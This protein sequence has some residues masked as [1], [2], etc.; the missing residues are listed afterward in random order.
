MLDAKHESSYHAEYE[1]APPRQT[2]PNPEPS[3]RGRVD[4]VD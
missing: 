1:Q 4:A 2:R 3:V